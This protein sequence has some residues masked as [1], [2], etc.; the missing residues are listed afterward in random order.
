MI[1]QI[2]KD[3]NNMNKSLIPWT[4]LLVKKI[5]ST[6]KDLSNTKILEVVSDLI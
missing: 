6:E 1:Y 5:D 2:H 3:T 4:Q